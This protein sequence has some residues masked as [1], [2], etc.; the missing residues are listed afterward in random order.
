VEG[1]VAIGAPSGLVVCEAAGGATVFGAAARGGAE[2]V[3]AGADGD[4]AIGAPSGPILCEATNVAAWFSGAGVKA[5]IAEPGELE[6]SRVC[7][8]CGLASPSDA[9]TEG[10][11]SGRSG[12]LFRKAKLAHTAATPASA[13]A[14]AVSFQRRG[15]G[16][17]DFW[18]SVRGTIELSAFALTGRSLPRSICDRE[19]LRS[20]EPDLGPVDAEGGGAL[21]A[22]V[23]DSSARFN[24]AS[25]SSA[26]TCR[27][28][29]PCIGLKSLCP[30][31]LAPER[32]PAPARPSRRSFDFNSNTKR[33]YQQAPLCLKLL[34]DNS[35]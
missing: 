31:S 10:S 16:L 35:N 5:G 28:G 29:A 22:R 26:F 27:F 17:V 4:V 34:F 9:A 3:E 12:A 2:L 24:S 21:G 11:R 8:F 32:C 15:L 23:D 13:S 1:A 20:E 30:I 25:I 33:S 6:G 18:R 14:P 19:L 7:S